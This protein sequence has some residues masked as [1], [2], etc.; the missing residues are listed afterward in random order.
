M[1]R[2]DGTR[3][4]HGTRIGSSLQGPDGRRQQADQRELLLTYPSLPHARIRF[5]HTRCVRLCVRVIGCT[6]LP[7]VVGIP[8]ICRHPSDSTREVR[9]RTG[10]QLASSRSQ[11]LSLDAVDRR[12]RLRHQPRLP[13][14]LG[15]V[16]PDQACV[17]CA[18]Q[19]PRHPPDVK[20]STRKIFFSSMF[21]ITL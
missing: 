2:G 3:H 6:Q 14:H 4:A 10:M 18:G 11:D 13:L 19:D 5:S 15:P 17:S 20:Y 21:K 9:V 1:G 12:R 8:R 16:P 7:A